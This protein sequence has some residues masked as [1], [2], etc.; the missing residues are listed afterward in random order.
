MMRSG[1]SYNKESPLF[2]VKNKEVLIFLKITSI[3]I[4]EQKTENTKL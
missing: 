1:D 3:I 2:F 4:T